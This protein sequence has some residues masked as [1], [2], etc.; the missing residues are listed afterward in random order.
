MVQSVQRA[1]EPAGARRAGHLLPG[2]GRRRRRRH[3]APARADPARARAR[4]DRVR[5]GRG[6]QPERLRRRRALRRRGDARHAR[7]YADFQ[8]L[9]IH[10]VG[11]LLDWL[12]EPP[13]KL[14]C[15]GDPDELDGVERAPKAHFGDAHVHLEVAAVL[16]RVRRGRRDEGR[17]ASTSSP[18]TWGS[19]ASETIA[20]GDGE[21]DVELVEW[22]GYGIAVENAHERV[23]AVADWICPSAR[24][25]RRRAGAR[26]ASRLEAMI[27]LR[28]ARNDPDAFRAALARRG[29]GEAFDELLAADERWR[30]LVPQVDELRAQQKLDG[31]PTPE[32][33]EELQQRQG[34]AEGRRGASSRPP[35]PSAT[36]RSAKVPNLPHESAADGDPRR[37]RDRRQEW[38]EPT[39][40]R[41]AP[42]APRARRATTWSAARRS[43]ARASA[44]S[45]ATRRGSRSRSTAS[46]ST[47]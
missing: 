3:L 36:R 4:G 24:G 29:A 19:R 38:G 42:R 5:R 8:H 6:L 17:R 7:D 44:S 2:R 43:R 39:T 1:L 13:T 35:R 40:P 12:A 9:E 28:A 30:A 16:P 11:D 32:Q 27:D 31:K 41:A 26:G 18:S 34:G 22:A 46:R 14:V 10:A 33:L 21:N 45:S 37:G 23:K 47:G 25:R 15:V 20:F